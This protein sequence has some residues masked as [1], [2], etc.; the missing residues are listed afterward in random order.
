MKSARISILAPPEFKKF[1]TSEARKAG[2]SVSELVRRRCGWPP[3]EDDALLA[4][5]AD[6]LRRAVEDARRSLHEG[7]QAVQ[8][9]LGEA[10]RE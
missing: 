7:L 2:I 1:L 3:S 9:V 10:G 4:T 5:M 6:E 8:E